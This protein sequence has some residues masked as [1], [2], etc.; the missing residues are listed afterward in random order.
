MKLIH[1]HG[2]STKELK[3]FI[4]TVLSNILTCLQDIIIGAD[5]LKIEID[6]SQQEII[7]WLNEAT[8]LEPESFREKLEDIK[9]FVEEKGVQQIL[10]RS[11]EFQIAG[12]FEYWFEALDRI[13]EPNFIPLV[14]DV[15]RLRVTTTGI[16]E[17][18]F[19]YQGTKFKLTD[20]G[21]QRSERRKWIH[22][23]EGVTAIIFCIAINEYDMQLY[24]DD[25][26]NRMHESLELLQGVCKEKFLKGIPMLI[27]LNKSDLFKKKISTVDMKV[28][29]EDYTGG[30][31]YD[32]AI[33]YLKKKLNSVIQNT[34]PAY[35]HVTCATDT[36]NIN[37]VF[38][39]SAD[40][41]MHS[42]LKEAFE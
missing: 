22:C 1:L 14:N 4:P 35:I 34:R 15:L 19:E 31:N 30:C 7:R 29:F 20:V 3:E 16:V 11:N 5:K 17:T 8:E 12:S 24:E 41:I 37:F 27:F 9:K 32:N 2:Y 26:V 23:F 28:C 18:S 42:I 36:E 25:S 38:Q 33:E 10:S 39:A 13:A 40:I 21:G 6:L